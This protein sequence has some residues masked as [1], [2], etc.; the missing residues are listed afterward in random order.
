MSRKDR[1]VVITG[2]GTASAV[3]LGM[4]SLWKALMEGRSGARLCDTFDM[5]GFCCPFVAQL[6]AEQMD[7]KQYVP[8]GHRKATK[9]MARDIELAVAAAFEAVKDA[10]LITKSHEPA[11]GKVTLPPDRMG[12]HV[13]AGLIAAEENELTMAL[14]T[15]QTADG[16]IDIV[17]WGES[18]IQNI[19]PLWMLKYLPNMLASHVSIIHDCQGPSNTITCGEASSLLSL[20]ESMRVIGRDSAICCLSGGAESK[21]NMMGVLRQFYAGRLATASLNDDPSKVVRPFDADATGGIAGEGGGILV[22]EEL[23]SAR[24]RGAKIEVEMA[25]FGAS[26]SWCEDTIGVVAEAD[27]AG[28][29]QAIEAAMDEAGVKP[30][31]IDAIVPFGCGV[32]GIDAGEAAG[33]TR[34]FGAS[35][36]KIPLVT[37]SPATGN[38][39]AGF[40][41]L[42]A[43]VAVMC[44]RSQKLPARINGGRQGGVDA[45][46]IAARDAKLKTIVVTTSSLGGQNAA[47]VLRRIS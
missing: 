25:G 29:A 43:S 39:G 18:G 11:D 3:G 17:K 8:K 33:L 47:V 2:I 32:P 42:A 26:Q 28:I 37:I 30:G 31:E 35:L 36:A 9:V 19:T 4:E 21:V 5:S 10:G 22:L 7:I 16:E 44:L 24:A 40:G 14:A 12:C 41:A 20:G 15:S 23:E 6:P 1:R 34:A 38:C 46:S 27:G 13:G 45:G